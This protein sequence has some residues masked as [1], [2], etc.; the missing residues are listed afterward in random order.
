MYIN[1]SSFILMWSEAAINRERGL[2][3]DFRQGR[4]ETRRKEFAANRRCL[5]KRGN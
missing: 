4:C 5:L 2:Y 1:V 3:P